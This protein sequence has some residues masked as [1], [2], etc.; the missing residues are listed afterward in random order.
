MT[1]KE[2]D[3]LHK[4]SGLIVNTNYKHHITKITPLHQ[5]SLASRLSLRT[6]VSLR[7]CCKAWHLV[8][9]LQHLKL[10]F[11]HWFLRA[12]SV[13]LS[14]DQAIISSSI[15]TS[16]PASSA[17]YKP[18][19]CGQ[20]KTSTPCCTLIR[21]SLNMEK[22]NKDTLT[23]DLGQI[24]ELNLCCL[25]CLMSF[26]YDDLVRRSNTRTLCGELTDRPCV[27]ELWCSF[28]GER[29]DVLQ[30]STD[31]SGLFSPS[32]SLTSRGTTVPCAVFQSMAVKT[33]FLVAF[34]HWTIISYMVIIKY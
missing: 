9:V 3:V 25:W 24:F 30:T 16:I 20:E 15:F 32:V 28:F 14:S 19:L 11:L 8:V 23:S 10:W 27:S 33:R 29:F 17:S 22:E 12:H 31:V 1:W 13:N 5:Q 26:T 6:S 4:V 2:N 18:F 7:I 21:N 34:R